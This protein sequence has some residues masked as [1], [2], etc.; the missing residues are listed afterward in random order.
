MPAINQQLGFVWVR[1]SNP[2]ER[3]S[4]IHRCRLREKP[5]VSWLFLAQLVNRTA[6]CEAIE[7]VVARCCPSYKMTTW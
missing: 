3:F 5:V 2:R 6:F 4:I 7:V 1:D